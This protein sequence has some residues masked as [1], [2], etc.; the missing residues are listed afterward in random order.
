MFMENFPKAILHL[1]GDA[2]FVACEVARD[3]SLRGK[4]VVTGA[5]RGIA[6]AMSYEAKALGITRAM[7]IFQ[8]RKEYPQVIVLQSH[9]RDYEIYARRMY[10][11][12]RRYSDIVEEYSIDECFADISGLDQKRDQSFENILSEIQA[13]LF[14]E[15]G[16]SFSLGL[17]VTKVLAKVA[18]KWSKPRGL[19][20]IPQGSIG[21]YLKDLPVGKIWG[22]GG[23]TSSYLLARGIKTAQG[24]L[25]RGEDWV[26]ENCSR[27]YHEIWLELTGV[28][29]YQVNSN[30]SRTPKSLSSTGTFYPTSQSKVFIFSELSRHIEN[31]AGRARRLDLVPSGVSFFLKTADFRYLNKKVALFKKTAIP[32][33]LI[34]SAR[35][36]FN[37]LFRENVFYRA[38]GAT[39][40]GLTPLEEITKDLFGGFD[41]PESVSGVFEVVDELTEEF[42][43][44]TVFMG[45]S[46]PVMS[47]RN[48]REGKNRNDSKKHLN[49]PFLGKTK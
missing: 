42:G 15:L 43:R 6:S 33:V 5:E 27:P 11:I 4:P 14:T 9:Y 39:I 12:V 2:F 44:N 24:F 23:Q 40:Y 41:A 18:S 25:D 48:K 17:S 8:I 31:V 3:P 7:P 13:T 32:S 38:T 19:T 46:L 28:S 22:I 29:I 34:S 20:I 1:D 35:G 16:I 30:S 49:I 21:K 45:S 36:E 10:S 37:K 47:E 26:K